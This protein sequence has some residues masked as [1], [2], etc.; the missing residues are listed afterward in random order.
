MHISTYIFKPFWR[1]LSRNIIIIISISFFF[2]ISSE[3]FL[4]NSPQNSPGTLQKFLQNVFKIC[5]SRKNF[6]T[7]IL[8]FLV[9]DSF[10]YDIY[11]RIPSS[12]YLEISLKNSQAIF[13][14]ESN[15]FPEMLQ[16][17]FTYSCRKYSRIFCLTFL[18]DFQ[19][20][21]STWRWL[22]SSPRYFIK[23]LDH[24]F[25]SRNSFSSSLNNSSG[26]FFCFGKISFINFF[27][28]QNLF[29]NGMRLFFKKS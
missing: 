10:R 21:S 27:F 22:S 1:S 12:N 28:C 16:E 9:V 26:V 3:I 25:F 11:S 2:G 5:S 4:K 8:E 24:F 20:N 15:V 19:R 6:S 23:E 17:Y 7:K 29:R 18:K 13:V 14:E